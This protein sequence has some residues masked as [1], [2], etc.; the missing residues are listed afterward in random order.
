M[1]SHGIGLLRI[2]TA[3]LAAMAFSACNTVEGVGE[4]MSS[5]GRA[6]TDELDDGTYTARSTVMRA[7]PNRD[8][9][10]VVSMRMN[11]PVNVHGCLDTHDWCDVSYGMDRGWIRAEDIEMWDDGRRYVFEERSGLPRVSF[12]FGYWDSNYRD[13]PWYRDRAEWSVRY[14]AYN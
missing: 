7:A 11:T 4:D 9:P 3:I 2:C 5:V 8:F 14:R 6:I 1:S 10:T 13:R 12:S